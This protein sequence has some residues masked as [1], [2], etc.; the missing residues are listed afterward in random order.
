MVRMVIFIVKYPLECHVCSGTGNAP[1]GV[2]GHPQCGTQ[3]HAVCGGVDVMFFGGQFHG[4]LAIFYVSGGH[5]S[6]ST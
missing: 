4:K 6:L 2:D 1:Y 5:F 3:K